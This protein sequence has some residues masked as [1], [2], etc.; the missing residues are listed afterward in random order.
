MTEEQILTEIDGALDKAKKMGS[1]GGAVLFGLM[2]LAKAVVFLAG[3][4]DDIKV[5]HYPGDGDDEETQRTM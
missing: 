5:R 3:K 2:A 1:N 4:F